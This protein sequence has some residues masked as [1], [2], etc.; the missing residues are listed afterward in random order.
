MFKSYFFHSQQIND[1]G[2]ANWDLH[3]A[4]SHMAEY[5]Q[6]DEK[7]GVMNSYIPNMLQISFQCFTGEMQTQVLLELF[8]QSISSRELI[9]RN[10]MC[11]T[12]LI[13][14]NILEY[15]SSIVGSWLK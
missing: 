8:S 6:L 7:I 12:V 3:G 5:R 9:V 15:A 1:S 4:I 13:P 14:K 2:I 10:H 11:N